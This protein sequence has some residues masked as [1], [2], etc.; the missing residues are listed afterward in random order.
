[1]IGRRMVTKLLAGAGVWPFAVHAQ[2]S[3][4]RIRHVA[5]I[6]GGAAGD[7]DALARFRVLRESLHQ[8]GWVDG[9]NLRVEYRLTAGSAETLRKDAV[10]LADAAPDVI[11]ASGASLGEMLKATRTVPV[12][13][14]FAVDPVGSGYVASLSRPG[15]NATGFLLF[16]FSMNAKWVELLKEVAPGVKRVAVLRDA[17]APTGIG[18][19]AVIQAA[20]MSLGLEVSP[21][22]L[23]DGPEIER[24]ISAVARQGGSGLIVAASSL[25]YVH[26]KLIIAVA[27]RHGLPAIYYERLFVTEGGLISYGADLDDQLRR[28]AVYVDRILKGEKPA[29]LPVQAPAKYDLVINLKTAKALGLDVA[30]AVLA[31]ALEVIE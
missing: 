14:P 12:V 26:R 5:V 11:V 20:A 18:Q 28:T 4:E 23:H 6:A 27:A 24:G 9:R 30:P 15:G 7:P 2:Q 16:E 13:F 8:L 1:M 31:R 25:A 29:D 21:V 10:D 22:N 3:S 19:F 17:A